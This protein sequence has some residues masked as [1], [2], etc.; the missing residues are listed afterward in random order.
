MYIYIYI[1][2]VSHRDSART[3]QVT[4]SCFASFIYMQSNDRSLVVLE[5]EEKAKKDVEKTTR[6]R[7]PGSDVLLSYDHV[8][9][10]TTD[11]RW[12]CGYTHLERSHNA[13]SVCKSRGTGS[14]V[15][16]VS[17]LTT[18]LDPTRE[19]DTRASLIFRRFV[20]RESVEAACLSR[21]SFLFMRDNIVSR[22]FESNTSSIDLEETLS[23]RL[24][25]LHNDKYYENKKPY[26]FRY[27]HE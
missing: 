5:L 27:S 17:F 18:R 16:S 21:K 13:T 20:R 25:N 26:I 19:S 22:F 2:I 1:C 3:K 14:P 11:E 9:A 15:I 6:Y 23:F 8:Q 24:S 10:N 7:E 12:F 4:I